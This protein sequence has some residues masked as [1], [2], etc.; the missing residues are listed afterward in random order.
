METAVECT[1]CKVV[2][3]SWSAPGSPIRYYQCPFCARTH[4]SLYGEVFQRRAG[5]RLVGAPVASAERGGIPMASP[6]DVRWAR[7]KATAARWFARLEAE[8]RPTAP[9][10]AFPRRARTAGPSDDVPEADPADVVEVG[11]RRHGRA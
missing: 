3:T 9:A 4:S 7:V 6:E 10:A 8:Q 5:A 2:M 11:T 1:H